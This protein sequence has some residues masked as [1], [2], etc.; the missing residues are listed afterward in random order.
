MDVRRKSR[1]AVIENGVA[2]GKQDPF[3][4]SLSSHILFGIF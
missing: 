3:A 4:Y 2:Q 1:Y